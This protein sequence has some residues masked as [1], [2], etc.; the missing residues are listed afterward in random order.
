MHTDG[1][2][3]PL[4]YPHISCT[5]E[6][7]FLVLLTAIQVSLYEYRDGVFE[8]TH[9]LLPH[10]SLLPMYDN[11]VCFEDLYAWPRQLKQWHYL[12]QYRK[13]HDECIHHRIF[14]NNCT[15]D[16]KRTNSG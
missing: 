15:E 11:L 1:R 4:P 9:R 2:K 6:A 8:V 10:P 5:F 12:A 3:I 16:P 7:R 14:K 13:M